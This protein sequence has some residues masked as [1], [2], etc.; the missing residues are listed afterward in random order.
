MDIDYEQLDPGIRNVVRFLRENGFETT[1]SGDGSKAEAMDCA[2]DVP[3]VFC[4]V[5]KEVA[6]DEADR[7]QRLICEKLQVDAGALIA[8]GIAVELTYSPLDQ[9]CVLSLFGL[10]DSKL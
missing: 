6:F 2:L 5:P 9:V 3:N 10:D 7:L 1:D 8:G 4:V